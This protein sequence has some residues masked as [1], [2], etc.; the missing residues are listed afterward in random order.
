MKPNDY[1]FCGWASRANMRCADGVTIMQDAFK[2]QDGKQVSLVWQHRWETPENILGH[3]ILENRPEGVYAYCRFNDSELARETK[4]RVEHG[5][6]NSMSIVATGLTKVGS[7][8]QH[9]VIR[10]VSLVVAGANPG[11]Y[12]ESIIKHGVES[13]DEAVIYTGEPL[14]LCHSEEKPKD[15]QDKE[16]NEEG[17]TETIDDVIKTMNEKQKNV[18][19]SLIGAVLENGKK[20]QSND[21][22]KEEE[23]EEVKHNVFE[24]NVE[25]STE[26]VLTHADQEAI[27]KL[28]KSSSVGSLKTAI[29][30]YTE[31]NKDTLSHGIE[32]IESLFPE[33]KDVRPG[34]PEML[35]T[36]QGWIGK[37][38]AKVHRSPISRIRT[39][40]ADLRKIDELRAKGYKKGKEK[41][42]IGNFKLLHRTTDPQTVFVKSKIDRDDIIDITDFDVVQYLY[43]IDRMNLNEELA[44]AIMIGDGREDGDEGKI[45]SDKIR[46]IW[47]D[48]DLYTIHV[49]VDI[50]K[51]KTELQGTNTAMSFGENYIYAEAIVQ[52]LLYA[53]EQYKG[54]GS[55]DFF[56]TPHLVNVMLLAR[57]M[58]GR[59]IYDNVNEL[60]AALNVNEIITA[61]QFAGK[62]RTDK[63][64]KKH[65]LLG[66]MVDLNDYYLGANKGGE[67][68]H[69]TDFDIDFNQEKS[70]LETRC[71]GANT[72][73]LSAIALELPVGE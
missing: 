9:G 8:V 49:D 36:D 54:S 63:E 1:D 70:L 27:I 43:N 6:I 35:T 53:R 57:D 40:Q 34:A 18:M 71:S 17:K 20:G 16:E 5:D 21:S 24:G 62:Q 33:Y 2:D 4:L 47:L 48:D 26:N 10:E 45:A 39:R 46:P 37:V 58:N 61:E 65:E 52:T 60:R 15:N 42:E 44:T 55:P 23:E 69:F 41:K 30:I 28:A 59:R 14:F 72:R 3:A 64:Q 29:E 25:E 68:T 19:Y 38:L 7:L 11:A 51:M 66:I 13:D 50:D 73:V 31:N 12:I 56:C 32:S 67:I 22:E